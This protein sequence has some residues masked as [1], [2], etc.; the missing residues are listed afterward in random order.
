ME[1]GNDKLDEFLE[2]LRR[3][4]PGWESFADTRFVEAEITY[5]RNAAAK[6]QEALSPQKLRQL[7]DQGQH[8]EFIK[9]LEKIGHSTNLLYMAVPMSGDLGVLYQ[10]DLDKPAFCSALYELIHGSEPA[11]KRLSSYAEYL[12]GHDLPNKWTFPTYFLFLC[13]PNSEMFI[14]PSIIKWFLDF[15]DVPEVYT[16]RPSSSCYLGVKEICEKL[17]DKLGNL[18][19]NDMIDIQSF[20]YVAAAVA[21]KSSAG[22]IESSRLDEFLKLFKEFSLTYLDSEQGRRHR[23]SYSQGRE[24]ALK[25]YDSI[26][27]ASGRG[28]DI[29][30]VVLL[31]LLPYSDSDSNRA[32]GAWIH[33]APCIQGDLKEWFQAKGWARAE[34][35]PEIAK[36]IIRFVRRCSE[37]PGGLGAAC[38]EF[39]SLPYA[40]GFQTGMLTPILNALKPQ[41]FIIANNKSRQVINYFARAA[42]RQ[43]L[44][45]YPALNRKGLEL[46]EELAPKMREIADLAISNNDLFDMFCHWLV[47]VK[48]H[49]LGK[50]RYWKISPGEDAWN[51]SAC[52]DGGFIAIGWDEVGDLSGLTRKEFDQ[53]WLETG[54]GKPDWSRTDANQVWSFINLKEGDKIIANRRTVEVLGI[55]EVTGDYYFVPNTR[56]G[57]RVPVDWFDL[58]KRQVKKDGWRK[59]IIK[60]SEDE[61]REVEQTS[62]GTA[63]E[64]P[65][66]GLF[67]GQAFE[68]LAELHENPTQEF[69]GSKRE[70][71]RQF[72][73]EPIQRI[74]KQVK[75]RLSPP[76]LEALETE[77]KI[78]GKIPKNDWGKGGTWDFYW[79]AFYPKGSKRIE[80][81]QLFLSISRKVLRF[82]F[83][84]GAYG[85]TQ[86]ERFLNNCE[87]YKEDLSLLFKDIL[88]SDLRFSS[89]YTEKGTFVTYSFTDWIKN[90][91]AIGVDA[92]ITLERPFAEKMQEIEIVGDV[93]EIFK[94]LYPFVILALSNDPMPEITEYLE[95]EPSGLQPEY[96]LA[97]FAEETGFEETELARWVRAIN[98]KKQAILYG[99]PGTG[100]T[101]I[102][103]RLARHLISGSD[104]FMDVLQFHPA[105]AYEDFMQGIRP[106]SRLDGGLEYPVVEG[107]FMDFCRRARSVK[108][109][110]VLVIDEINRANLARVFGELMYLLEYRNAQIPL[111]VGG[112]F[113]IPE[114][115]FIIGTMNTAD[116]SIA[117]VDYALRRRF[118]FIP[119]YPNYQ[120][121]KSFHED[122]GFDPEGLISILKRLNGQ[123]GDPHY[124][125]GITFFLRKDI[126]EEIE[127]IW[128]MEIE[129]YLEEYFFDQRKKVDEFRW[130][131]VRKDILPEEEA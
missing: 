58:K 93:S 105:Y 68:L 122:T 41:D 14:K 116:R 39:L 101:Y 121:L 33:M 109:P 29:T 66:G 127:D 13:H 70:E 99:P 117:L 90:P 46:I 49:D 67:K 65:V 25:N 81:S 11:E 125:V 45:D 12:R 50:A 124:E 103:E 72:V 87:R 5:K 83:S 62:G 123:I 111:A 113:Q 4:F 22:L 54:A 96:S 57:H 6:A 95:T 17:K 35:W 97:T 27:A 37:D 88:R 47:A 110:C 30:D 128:R 36:A 28:E 55:G 26:L 118:V 80:D 24:Q 21:K 119:L 19:A 86:R 38:R 130:E 102:A 74:L 92:A 52:R 2:L 85:S 16:P 8:D 43:S 115:I 60:L 42:Y 9:L 61:F 44:S 18:G 82:G 108:G 89:D 106:K 100:K 98:R 51:W 10:K 75:E 31:K 23:T 77:K 69:Y 114:N 53:R 112:E 84:I 120:V 104:G 63:V 79:G 20:V 34:D 7:I 126:S 48:N 91:K 64:A 131:Q 59:T 107:R 76:M 32:K 15:M 3:H 73:E 94:S 71:F 129:P 40:K 56:H 1:I 78:F